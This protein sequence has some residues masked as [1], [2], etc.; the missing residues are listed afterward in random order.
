MHTQ[1]KKRESRGI[2]R[3][4]TIKTPRS[5]GRRRAEGEHKQDQEHRT[6]KKAASTETTP[7]RPRKK[8]AS[9]PQDAAE[10]G[11]HK[12]AQEHRTPKKAAAD[13][14]RP[15]LDPDAEEHAHA[16]GISA[17]GDEREE[18]TKFEESENQHRWR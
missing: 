10:E 18:K 8:A 17:L 5:R 7:N 14:G 16:V 11:E 13:A 4:T 6:P 9:I 12:E 15:L 3:P 1:R 2:T